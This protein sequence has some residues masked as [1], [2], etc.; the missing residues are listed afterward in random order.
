M[1]GRRRR[2]GAGDLSQGVSRR[3]SVRARNQ[4]E[5]LVVHDSPQHRPEPGPRSRA[6]HGGRRQRDRR[7]RRRRAA[8]GSSL[9][10]RRNA[11][12]AAAAR[13][14]RRPSSGRRSTRC[15][16]RFVRPSGYETWKSFPTPKSPRCWSIPVGTVMSR[17]SRG[18]R[19]L[20]ERLNPA[21]LPPSPA[22]TGKA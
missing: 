11:R 16:R 19:M 4:P 12:N 13:D 6:R 21:R 17:I 1:T 7:P 20:F 2:S 9:Q 15:R 14:A 8:A 3:R 22:A 10:R 5:G 18:R